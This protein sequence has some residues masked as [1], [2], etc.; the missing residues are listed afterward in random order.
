MFKV[1]Q[2]VRCIRNLG[3]P[4]LDYMMGVEGVISYVLINNCVKLQGYPSM[5]FLPEELKLI[6]RKHMSKGS[7]TKAVRN[8]F[9]S[10]E[11]KAL[12]NGGFMY[13]TGSLTKEGRKV[14]LNM[15]IEQD[16]ELKAKVVEAALAVAAEKEKDK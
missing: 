3:E 11:D 2:K 14:V 5:T 6:E 15:L 10:K 1:G 8:A 16:E 12:I 7:L 4:H 9:R 13:E